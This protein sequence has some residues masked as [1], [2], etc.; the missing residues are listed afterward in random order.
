MD[1]CVKRRI[2]RVTDPD[3]RGNNFNQILKQQPAI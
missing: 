3:F 2:F 1:G